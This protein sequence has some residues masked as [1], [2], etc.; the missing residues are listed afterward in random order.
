MKQ[1]QGKIAVV[2]GATRGAGRAIAVS[3][4]EAGATVYCTGRSVRGE[5]ASGPNRPET[6]DETA[7]SIST[8]GGTAFPVRVDHSD[9]DQV[10]RLFERVASEQGKLDI[11]IN[12]I[13]GGE[14]LSD[15]DHPFWEQS[16]ENGLLMQRRAVHTHIITSYFGVPLMLPQKQGLVVE[17]TDGY[18]LDYRGRFFYDLA[19]T[20][21]IR[22]A[23]GLA[24]ELGPRGIT[25]LGVTPGFLRSE[26]MLDHFG[27][28]EENWRDAVS[29]EPLFAY[30]ETPYYLGRA[31]AALAADPNVSGKA[32]KTYPT[33]HL[34]KEYGFTDLDGT[35]PDWGAHYDE[36]TRSEKSEG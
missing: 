27:V 17:V 15:W 28:K 34:Y 5:P 9:P 22:L 35:Q 20:S 3:L 2:A 32:G 11:L 30:S 4:G 7:E 31:V 33:W 8:R 10:K 36:F 21:V 16:L 24:Q 14:Q 18:T 19:K 23:F 6:I 12:D 29:Q 26:E 13:W 25:A 1:L